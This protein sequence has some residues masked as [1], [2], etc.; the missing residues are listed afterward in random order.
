[1]VQEN[2]KNTG[3]LSDQVARFMPARRHH[4]TCVGLFFEVYAWLFRELVLKP[5][6]VN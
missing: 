3:V 4:L 6:V 1:M 2:T 5:W